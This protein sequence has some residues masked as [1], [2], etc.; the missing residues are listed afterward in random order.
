MTRDLNILNSV[1]LDE[2][3]NRTKKKTLTTT[4]NN[5]TN[6]NA[7]PDDCRSK[8]NCV[9]LELSLEKLTTVY[10]QQII[11]PPFHMYS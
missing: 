2:K 7:I 6:E 11:W 5:V 3:T 10:A 9:W 8:T 1:G 4:V